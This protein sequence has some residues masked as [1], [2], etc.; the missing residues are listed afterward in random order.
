MAEDNQAY[1]IVMHAFEKAENA[2]LE[3]E[4]AFSNFLDAR[5]KVMAAYDVYA[6][7][8]QKYDEFYALY[9]EAYDAYEKINGL[10]MRTNNEL[11]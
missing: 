11:D 3:K 6:S 4:E 9:S 1:D 7:A 5:K 8:A 2:Q 10:S